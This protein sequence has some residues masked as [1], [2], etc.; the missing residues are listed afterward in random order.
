MSEYAKNVFGIDA[1]NYDLNVSA[2]F[3]K[4][5]ILI[6]RSSRAATSQSAGWR[7]ET[8]ANFM[9][10]E[11]DKSKYT[12]YEISYHILGAISRGHNENGTL[13]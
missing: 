12:D 9:G 2:T 5:G 8:K 4:D 10:G 11:I 7:C 6:D 3:N 1:Y 13:R